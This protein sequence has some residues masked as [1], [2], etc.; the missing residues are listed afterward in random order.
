MP[1]RFLKSLFIF[2]K[3]SPFT[4]RYFLLLFQE[5]KNFSLSGKVFSIM[6]AKVWDVVKKIS[7]GF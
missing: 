7:F 6:S 5:W 4:Y 2:Q 3:I 1:K